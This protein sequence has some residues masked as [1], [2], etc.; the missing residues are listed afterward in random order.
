MRTTILFLFS[1][2][3][4]LL[5]ALSCDKGPGR[6]ARIKLS[7][8]DVYFGAEGGTC[9]ITSNL[10]VTFDKIYIVDKSGN[11]K[12]ALEEEGRRMPNDCKS[13]E[14]DW[15]KAD[16][17]DPS[18]TTLITFCAKAN[19]TADSRTLKIVVGT[20]ETLKCITIHQAGAEGH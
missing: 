15:I 13:I 3:L 19:G 8:T 16:I 2:A 4:F 1:A 18:G 17:T 12:N 11:L 20:L 9:T 7:Q 6:N 10:E 14:Y 5:T